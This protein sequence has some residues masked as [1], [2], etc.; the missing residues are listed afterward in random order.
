M[1]HCARALPDCHFLIFNFDVNCESSTT[2]L[3]KLLFR[4]IDL[5]LCILNIFP[6]CHPFTILAFTLAIAEFVIVLLQIMSLDLST[7]S[8]LIT[9]PQV[10]QVNL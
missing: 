10:F 8:L 6:L 3:S 2:P 9:A 1:L 4:S 5:P 7:I